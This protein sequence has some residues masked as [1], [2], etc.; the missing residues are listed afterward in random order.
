M[1]DPTVIERPNQ[2]GS[3][4]EPGMSEA[5]RDRIPATRLFSKIVPDDFPQ[6]ASLRDIIRNDTRIDSY[7]RGDIVLRRDD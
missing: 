6:T 5:D 3:P 1:I 7:S 4:L 2:W